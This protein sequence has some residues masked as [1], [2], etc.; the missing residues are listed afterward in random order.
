MD[1]KNW[2]QS[3]TIWAALIS[4]IAGIIALTGHTIDAGTQQVLV[5]QISAVADA[6]TIVAG[7][8][9][10]WGRTQVKTTIAPVVKP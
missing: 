8:A 7:L 10:G 2:W 6:V 3:K 1:S 4:A 5:N 9:A